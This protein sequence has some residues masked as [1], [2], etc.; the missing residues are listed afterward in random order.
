M[1]IFT[2]AG[3]PASG[4]TGSPRAI[5]ASSASASA[6]AASAVS[7]TTAFSSGFTACIRAIAASHSSRAEVS[8][9]RTR[10]AIVVAQACQSS[11]MSARP[12]CSARSGAGPGHRPP[13]GC[14][15]QSVWRLAEPRRHAANRSVRRS[16]QGSRPA[17]RALRTGFTAPD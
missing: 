1:L 13:E 16:P 12:L 10:A 15:G 7:S 6:S 8:R 3:T 9:E 11:V 14:E 5:A 17:P 4:P 2:V